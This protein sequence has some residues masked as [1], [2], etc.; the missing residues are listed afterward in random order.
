VKKTITVAETNNAVAEI[1]LNESA[2]ALTENVTVAADPFERTETNV[3]SEQTLTKRELHELSS[4]LVCDPLRAAQSLP[5][6]AA[7]DDYRSEFAVRGAGFDRVG[8][9]VDGILTDNFV[10]TI[11]GG[12]PDT[13]SL[14]VINADTVDSVTLL[15]GAFPVNFGY[16]S[17][18]I[19]DVRTRDGNRVKPTGRF[20]A[21]LSGLGGVVDGPFDGGQGAYLFAARKSYLGYL[22]RRFNDQ[23]EDTNNPPVLSF[24]DGQAKVIY[25]LTGRDRVGFSVILG[26]F[27]FDRNRDR[28]LLGFNQVFRGNS[29]NFMTNGYWATTPNAQWFVQTRVFGLRS[30]F[31]NSNRN[32]DRL[33]DGNRSQFGVRLDVNYQRNANHLEGGLYVRRLSVN[34][35]TTFF[36]FFN[37]LPVLSQSFDRSGVEQGYYVQDTW[38]NHRYGLSLTGGLRA[39]HSGVTSETVVA[40]R[41]SFAW[42][43]DKNWK[44]RFGAGR[45]HQFPD[46]EQMFGR[47]GNPELKSHRSTHVNA[48]VERLLGER[49]RILAEVFDREDR[50]LFFSLNEPRL[51]GG[52][53]DFSE[54]PFQNSL[55]GHARGFELTVQRR[56]ANKLAGWISYAYTRTELTDVRDGFVFPSDADQRH[57]VNVYANYR[58]T[59][60]WNL[61]SELR[62]GSGQPIPGFFGQ[63][64]QGYFLTGER[65]QTRVP[66][67][68][69]IDVRLSKAFLFRRW[70]MTLTGEVLNVLNRHNVRYAGFDFFTFDGRVIGQLDRV[71]PILP[72]AGVVIEF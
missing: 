55:N 7:N 71:F 23:F 65:N 47:L 11:A 46:F 60:T 70:K 6:V 22:V 33:Q 45:Y 56:S 30:T 8:L 61:S 10:H 5:G 44:L 24:V 28:D 48:S 64:S 37:G 36:D 54:F 27:T 69:R 53:V 51:S 50:G 18:S 4:V 29:R 49:T 3:P 25:D 31:N 21:A 59:D 52:F 12:Y 41:G 26:D 58:F 72:S 62:Y 9:F 43:I 42:T 63:D 68:N 2:A 38:T 32:D 17:A 57:T 35:A 34:S 20:A 66:F 39:E 40:P 67:Y 15:S 13:G 1:A 19:L 16:R 14:S